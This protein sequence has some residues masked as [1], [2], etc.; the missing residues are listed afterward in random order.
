MFDDWSL[1]E[2]FFLVKLFKLIGCLG[3]SDIL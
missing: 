3:L 2:N 1:L